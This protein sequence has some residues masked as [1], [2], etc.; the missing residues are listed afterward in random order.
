MQS[1][2]DLDE[3]LEELLAWLQGLENT[4]LSLSQEELPMDIPSTEQLIADHKEFMEN[5]QKRQ[6]EVDRICK[7][8]QIKP[9]PGVKDPRKLSKTK[10][11]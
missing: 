7:A 8:K 5:T 1:L 4:L 10:P 9:A 6:V 2:K 11:M 3:S